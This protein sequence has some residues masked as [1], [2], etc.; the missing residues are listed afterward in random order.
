[1]IGRGTSEMRAGRK[2]S[3]AIAMAG[4]L[5]VSTAFGAPSPVAPDEAALERNFDALI[6]PAEMRDWMKQL[7]SQPNHVGSP[8]DKANA[9]WILAQF[10]SWGWDAH[11]E[12][13]EVLY[14]TPISETLELL[15]P[16]NHSRRRCRSRRSPAI[17]ARPRPTPRCPPMSPIR[18]TATSPPTRLRQLR[19]AGRLQ[20]ARAAG[21]QR[22]GQDRH[23]PLRRRLA[24][25]EAEARAGAR[26]DRLHH[27][28]RPG[29]RTAIRSTRPIR[30]G[31]CA[32]RTACSAARCTTWR[33]IP[34]IR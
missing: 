31:R 23:R 12:T 7:A 1:M 6:H 13:F 11:I 25:A 16:A 3:I 17:R 18:A 30:R 26:R 29:A 19:D 10:K 8:H 21:R 32:R 14:P 9:E 34:A 33:S 24:R 15:G 4:F 20:D 5:F 22:Q 2:L 28:F 27:L